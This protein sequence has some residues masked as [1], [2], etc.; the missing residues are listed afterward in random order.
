[1]A[2]GSLVLRPL[3][4]QGLPLSSKSSIKLLNYKKAISFYL[5]YLL[6]VYHILLKCKDLQL[7]FYIFLNFVFFNNYL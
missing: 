4:S 3:F 6:K 2:L 5:L 7:F 1:M